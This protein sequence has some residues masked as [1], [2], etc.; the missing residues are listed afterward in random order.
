VRH[1]VRR[2]L[3]LVRRVGARAAD[4]KLSLRVDRQALESV[5][6]LLSDMGVDAGRPWA[7]IHPGASAASRRY[8]PGHFSKAAALLARRHGWQIV[9][10]GSTD[11][12]LLVDGVR[13]GM[14]ARSWSL[15]GRLDLG[16]LAAL[17]SL[18]PLLI[19]NNTGPVHIAAAVGTPV[20]DL[21]ALTNPQHTPWGVPSRVLF[22]D[23]PCKYCYKSVCPEGTNA[24]LNRVAP[25]TVAEAALG[26]FGAKGA[27]VPSAPPADGARR[28]P[29]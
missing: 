13:A 7:V 12:R 29:C 22:H 5:K 26:L 19:S 27:G 25:E 16:H 10:T 18:A 21:Y 23:S 15:A 11:E 2:Q 3:D 6:S 1:E 9:F 8:A 20:V 28:L 4:E 14:G 17:L 24:C